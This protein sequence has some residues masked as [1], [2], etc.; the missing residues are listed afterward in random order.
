MNDVTYRGPPHT[1]L[2]PHRIQYGP[3][4]ALLSVR[5]TRL[6]EGAS[7]RIEEAGRAPARRTVPVVGPRREVAMTLHAPGVV[8]LL[9]A[10]VAACSDSGSDTADTSTTAA[11]VGSPAT[12][13]HDGARHDV[14]LGP[15]TSADTGPS[16]GGVPGP[17]GL[18]AAIAAGTSYATACP[19]QLRLCRPRRRDRRDP[20]RRGRRHAVRP[21]LD[22]EVLRHRCAPRRVGSGS[23]L[24]H[25]AVPHRIARR[26]ASCRA[27]SCSSRR[28][29]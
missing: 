14:R 16:G 28:A 21:R 18:R 20:V 19:R 4:P 9:L 17:P 27:I 22:H 3:Q 5:R 2:P 1:P 26:A 25:A 29:T 15:I 6:I 24:P 10:A 23:P 7:L 8:T 12:A 11:V 13:C